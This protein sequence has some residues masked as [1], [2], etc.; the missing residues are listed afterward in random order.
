[1]FDTPS[2]YSRNEI[3][4]PSGVHRSRVSGLTVTV[5]SNTWS[6]SPPSGAKTASFQC[7]SS[8]VAL[9]QDAIFAVL[10]ETAGCMVKAC[11]NCCALPP[12]DGI[13]HRLNEPLTS[14]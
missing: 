8:E 2:R 3:A 12:A 7:G 4:L 14:V 10:R 13:F 11:V 5:G 1:M 9:Y 6:G